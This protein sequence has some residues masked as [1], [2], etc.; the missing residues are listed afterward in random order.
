MSPGRLD[1]KVAIITG[2]ASGFGKGIAAK[3]VQEG[4]KVVIADLS[5]EA[6]TATAN[7]LG[8]KFVKA[9][10]TKTADWERL[11]T[12][13]LSTYGQLDIVV[14]NAGAT[15][16]NKPTE[17]VTE[18]EFDLVMNVNVKSIYVSTTVLLQYFMKENRPG[19][20]IQVA[21]TAGIR[22]RPRLTWYNASKGAVITATKSLAVEFGPKKIR[23]NAVSPVVGSTGMSVHDAPSGVLGVLGA[24]TC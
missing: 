24:T 20:F 6:G 5:E 9:D 15:Y 10:V 11:L 4:S 22:P 7:E 8:G 2:A 17:D 19:C 14:N 21:S 13:T 18:A 12:E 16:P 1:G 23:F 3:F